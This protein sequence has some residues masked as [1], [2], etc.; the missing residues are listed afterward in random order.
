MLKLK[1]KDKKEY[2]SVEHNPYTKKGHTTYAKLWTKCPV[3][4]SDLTNEKGQIVLLG[5]W[6]DKKHGIFILSDKLDDFKVEFPEQFDYKK[7]L[8]VEFI[9]PH[10]KKSLVLEPEH[11][12]TKCKAPMI[13]LKAFTKSIIQ[14][15]SRTGCKEHKL[16]LHKDD[17]WEFF[18]Q[19]YTDSIY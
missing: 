15:C 4:K 17:S 10:C 13:M 12:C 9:C 14:F 16:Y 19:A 18:R 8:T 2:V 5:K 3:C 11:N 1:L 6:N 7:E